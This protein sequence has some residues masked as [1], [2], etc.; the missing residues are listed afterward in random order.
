[1]MQKLLIA[2]GCCCMVALWLVFFFSFSLSLSFFFRIGHR[3]H[4]RASERAEIV[5]TSCALSVLRVDAICVQTFINLFVCLSMQLK[6]NS[7][8]PEND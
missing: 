7:M 1:M 8:G 4:L 5:A 6:K 2:C 3:R